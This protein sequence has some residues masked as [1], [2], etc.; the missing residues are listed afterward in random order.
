MV[1]LAASNPGLTSKASVRAALRSS[2]VILVL[3]LTFLALGAGYGRYRLGSVS[4]ALAFLRGGRLLVDE[5][6]KS[7][8]GVRAGSQVVI[9]YT[10]ANLSGR[11]LKLVGMAASCTCTVIEDIPMTLAMSET[12]MVTAK[13]KTSDGESD[14]SGSIRLFTDDIHSPEI[15]LAYLVRFAPTR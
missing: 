15:T 8:D 3:T 2:G 12:K 5:P 6:V 14:L 1:E 13:I 9:S 4:A 7:I 11:P 10:L